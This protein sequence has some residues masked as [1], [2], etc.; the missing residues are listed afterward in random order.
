MLVRITRSPCFPGGV[1]TTEEAITSLFPVS[2]IVFSRFIY[3]SISAFGIVF[4]CHFHRHLSCRR[5][6]KA[7]RSR[8]GR[9]LPALSFSRQA[10][11][12]VNRL[13]PAQL[14]RISAATK[15]FNDKMFDLKQKRIDLKQNLINREQSH[16]HLE[17][18]LNYL[19]QSLIDIQAHIDFV[20]QQKDLWVASV[21]A[22]VYR[23]VRSLG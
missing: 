7:H 22:Q 4:V 12:A 14:Q 20:Q 1:L 19:K 5:V 11:P 10:P 13:S 16:I 23:D 9:S 3:L 17:H 2:S 15:N 21:L 8:P 18:N 6:S